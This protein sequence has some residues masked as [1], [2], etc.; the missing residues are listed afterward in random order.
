MCNL[1]R[2]LNKILRGSFK[3]G[4][5]VRD[6]GCTSKQLKDWLERQ[7]EEG[8]TWGNYGNKS[9]QWSIDHEYPLSEVDLTKRE[10]LL[11]VIHYTNLQPMWHKDNISK[12]NNLV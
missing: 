6:L 5:A 2:G 12:S 9:D 7:F 4:S 11:P 10:L 8:M 1:R 3:S